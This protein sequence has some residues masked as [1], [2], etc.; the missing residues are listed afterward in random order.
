MLALKPLRLDLKGPGAQRCAVWSAANLCAQFTTGLGRLP[1][2]STPGRNA[3]SITAVPHSPGS[4]RLSLGTSLVT[5][6][7]KLLLTQYDRA[8]P[9][10]PVALP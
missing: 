1:A 5:L 7:L 10:V 9:C 2:Q 4:R 3:H 8:E 6:A